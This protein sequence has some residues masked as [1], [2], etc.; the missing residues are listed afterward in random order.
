MKTIRKGLFETNS[1]SC[2]CMNIDKK[3]I[4]DLD[5]VNEIRF[6]PNYEGFEI[7]NSLSRK[8]M[9]LYGAILNE[10]KEEYIDILK[11]IL[12]KYNIKYVF[13]KDNNFKEIDRKNYNFGDPHYNSGSNEFEV[14][15]LNYI[16]N[17]SSFYDDEGRKNKI[18]ENNILNYLFSEDSYICYG[19]DG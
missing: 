8:A 5:I 16:F 7:Y 2:H 6:K 4:K 19:M 11:K 12:D 1:S 14:D 9:Y 18:I 13:E 3:E 15:D 10:E 17:E